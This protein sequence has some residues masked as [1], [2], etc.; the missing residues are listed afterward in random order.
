MQEKTHEGLVRGVRRWDVVA[1]M[2]NA[3]IGASIFGLPSKIYV[4]TGSYSLLVFPACAL[5]FVLLVL[6]LAEVSSRFRETGGD[7]L[8]VSAA[9]GP[10][11]G[12][13]IGWI[14]LLSRISAFAMICNVM[15]NYLGFFWAPASSGLPRV[16]I[17]TGIT[18]ALA[19]INVVGVCRAAAVCNF[20]T[21]GKLIPLLV[22]IGV[23]LFFISPQ[24]YS[25]TSPPA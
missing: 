20:F 15:S 24:N 1:L 25:F 13:A 23:G 14:L 2:I 10:N 9:F 22:F 4:L 7:Y 6:C 8:Y 21:I 17:I 12:F 19:V 3:T 11:A 16:L 18:A 5:V